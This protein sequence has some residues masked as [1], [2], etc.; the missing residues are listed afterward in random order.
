MPCAGVHPLVSVLHMVVQKDFQLATP[1]N[2]QMGGRVI[3]DPKACVFKS[4]HLAE[5]H[6]MLHQN[7]NSVAVLSYLLDCFKI[8]FF[9]GWGTANCFRCELPDPLS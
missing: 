7:V 5:L 4:M 6:K 9:F 1:A 3:V 8:C 2:W